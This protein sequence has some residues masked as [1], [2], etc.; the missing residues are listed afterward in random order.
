[1]FGDIYVY[2]SLLIVS[3]EEIV[4]YRRDFPRVVLVLP[5]IARVFSGCRAIAAGTKAPQRVRLLQA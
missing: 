2:V 5:I 3:L 1:M 4:I